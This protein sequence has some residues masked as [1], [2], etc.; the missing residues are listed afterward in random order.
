MLCRDIPG[1]RPFRHFLRILFE[2]E[3]GGDQSV[4]DRLVRRVVGKVQLLVAEKAPAAVDAEVG[5]GNHRQIVRVRGMK[6]RVEVGEAGAM[7]R[8]CR[9][10]LVLDG[11]FVVDIF[12]H[13]D[14]DAV[15][16]VRLRTL[17]GTLRLFL[18]SLRRLGYLRLL[19]LI[20][21]HRSNRLCP[22]I[23]RTSTHN[24]A[25]SQARGQE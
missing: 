15:E 11:T 5:A 21:L 10:V 2:I 16:V 8:E 17:G 22:H 6:H 20:R 12:E 9:Q 14:Q 24:R 4:G 18:L 25:Q 19:G 23:L 13:D 3:P 1:A 7:L